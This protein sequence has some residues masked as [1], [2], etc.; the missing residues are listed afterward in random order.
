M[1]SKTLSIVIPCYN[2]KKTILEIL[3]RASAAPTDLPKEVVIVD[4]GSTDGTRDILDGLRDRYAV[5]LHDRNRGKGAALRTCFA[6][7]RGDIIL[8][9]DADL[10][11][12]PQD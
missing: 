10:E 3:A 6:A 8:V 1:P 5:I 12:N 7:A 4:D 2:E 9:Q 11:Y